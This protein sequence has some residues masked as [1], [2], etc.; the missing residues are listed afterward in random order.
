MDQ[1]R[2]GPVLEHGGGGDLQ[3]AVVRPDGAG[4]VALLA[5]RRHPA[6][7]GDAQ[8][9]GGHRP[10]R[11]RVQGAELRA[12]GGGGQGRQI[13][14]LAFQVQHRLV[15]AGQSGVH[16]GAV[17]AGAARGEACAVH[18]GCFHARFRTVG[19]LLKV[20]RATRVSGPTTRYLTPVPLAP[21]LNSLACTWQQCGRRAWRSTV[22]ARCSFR[23]VWV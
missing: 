10:A 6:P 15:G 21:R 23:G 12:V 4:G 9:V 17:E 18:V 16:Q 22:S 20:T 14:G 1:K 5:S 3:R 2:H 13:F 7:V 8:E 19:C 11:P